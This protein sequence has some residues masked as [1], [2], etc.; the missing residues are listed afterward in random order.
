M[1]RI[2]KLLDQI[3]KLVLDIP[4]KYLRLT[5]EAMNEIYNGAGPDWM[6]SFSRDI[7]TFLLRYFA[8][9]FLIHDLEYHFNTDTSDSKINRRNFHNA[10]KRMWK[11][12][13]II[14]AANFSWYNPRRWYWRTKGWLA[15]RACER[16]GWSAWIAVGSEK[17]AT[18]IEA[19][20]QS[21]NL[22]QLAAVPA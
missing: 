2:K 10:N 21:I 1:E 16:F 6:S 17:N 12:I 13:K 8:A 19:K 7:L 22:G 18:I 15:Y 4:S 20:K 3:S 9:A 14:N 5:H 11:N